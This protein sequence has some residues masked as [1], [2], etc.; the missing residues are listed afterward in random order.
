MAPRGASASTEGRGARWLPLLSIAALAFVLR[1]G[2]W[3]ARARGLVPSFEPPISFWLG[4]NP[5]WTV[6][7]ENL[8]RGA[9]YHFQ[10]EWFGDT[11]T[12]RPPLYPLLL[13]ALSRLFGRADL[14]PVLV[15]SVI[16]SLSAVLAALMS[17]RLF[18]RRAGLTAGVLVA[19]YP[20]YLN[21]DVYRQEIVLLTAV[22]AAAVFLLLRARDASTAGDPVG[23]GAMLGLAALTRLTLLAFVPLA[24]AWLGVFSARRRARG[25]AL[26]LAGV[27]LVITPWVVRNTLLLGRPVFSVSTGFGL[28]WS[29]NPGVLKYYP[30]ETIDRGTAEYWL[31]LPAAVRERVAALPEL[32]RDQ[33]FREQA[34]VYIKANPRSVARGVGLKALVAFGLVKSPV[35]GDFRDVLYL[36]LYVPLLLLA[37]LGAFMRPGRWPETAL[38]VLLF[39]AYLAPSLLAWSHTGHRIYVDLYL[40][41]LASVPIAAVTRRRGSGEDPGAAP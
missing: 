16:G 34:W 13:A 14:P 8:A 19:V 30:R 40:M 7:A 3:L 22:T 37:G 35:S 36:A 33:W 24:A 31:S 39:V 26:F 1:F 15:Q 5:E 9:G 12:N 4:G 38:F 29:H 2:L 17:A 23:A 28:W 21:H 41:V 10:S 6:L 20:Y 25:V 27:V 18:G 11:W 32:E